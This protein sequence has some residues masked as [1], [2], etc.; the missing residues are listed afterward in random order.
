MYGISVFFSVECPFMDWKEW[1]GPQ[2]ALYFENNLS[3]MPF[4]VLKTLS[5]KGCFYKEL[6]GDQ[7]KNIVYYRCTPG[8]G[9]V[10]V[11]TE[12]ERFGRN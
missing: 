12:R 4:K 11:E 9:V 3:C 1:E 2:N 8:G 5:N 6:I 10:G 7:K